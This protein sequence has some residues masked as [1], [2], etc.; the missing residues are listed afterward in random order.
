MQT[1][2]CGQPGAEAGRIQS[3]LHEYRV[4]QSLSGS[5]PGERSDEPPP[6]YAVLDH[7][8][9]SWDHEGSP[10][11]TVADL[12]LP[13]TQIDWPSPTNRVINSAMLDLLRLAWCLVTGLFRS[14]TALQAEILISA[15]KAAPRPDSPT[16]RAL[17]QPAE[18]P[19][20]SDYHPIRRP[21]SATL[22]LR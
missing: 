19:L 11:T 20:R 9:Q 15:C 4:H 8:I 21:P 7:Y 3:L 5:T 16:A 10:K 17:D 22:G 2:R 12:C 6:A 14:R 18:F 1:E 13:Q